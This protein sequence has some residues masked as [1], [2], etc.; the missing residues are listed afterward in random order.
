MCVRVRKCMYLCVCVCVCVCVC[1]DIGDAY[2]H[3]NL[4]DQQGVLYCLIYQL[5]LTFFRIST[6]HATSMRTR[7]FARRSYTLVSECV[8]D[9]V[10]VCVCELVCVCTCK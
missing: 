1:Y 10:F 2:G 9:C 3:R 8:C 7:H 6:N 5:A 4:S